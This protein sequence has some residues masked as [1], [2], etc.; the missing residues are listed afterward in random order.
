MDDLLQRLNA[1]LHE[2][3][4]PTPTVRVACDQLEAAG[5]WPAKTYNRLANES[6]LDLRNG[7]HA[8]LVVTKLVALAKATA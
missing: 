1:V 5:W 2:P 8:G 7:V 3:V 4:R 6:G